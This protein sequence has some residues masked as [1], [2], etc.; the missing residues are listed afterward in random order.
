ML[1]LIEE[2]FG[3]SRNTAATITITILV[4]V[5]GQFLLSIKSAINGYLKRK[6][7]RTMFKQV[8]E[9]AIKTSK[10]NVEI[11]NQVK[12]NLYFDKLTYLTKQKSEFFHLSLLQEIGHQT[13]YQSYFS[14]IENTV[15]FWK[16]TKRQRAFL[17][18]WETMTSLSYWVQECYDNIDIIRDKYNKHGDFKAEAM[19]RFQ[20]TSDSMA[21]DHNGK[22]V[23]ERAIHYLTKF[24]N[25]QTNFQSLQD[26]RPHI[27]HRQLI[28]R[29]RILNKDFKDLPITHNTNAILSEAT[30]QYESMSLLLKASRFQYHIYSCNFRF[31]YRTLNVALKIIQC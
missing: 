16:N 13:I 7:I 24:F 20:I 11:C 4:F 18:T 17:K 2:Y 9:G 1:D 29:L 12:R 25:I 28:V 30:Y 21:Y 27:L 5:T 26:R 6:A 8:V 31:F 14:G 10:K 15:I 19:K 23:E 3:I 22:N